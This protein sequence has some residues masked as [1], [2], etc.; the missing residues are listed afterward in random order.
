MSSPPRV[1]ALFVG[2]VGNFSYL[3]PR[4]EEVSSNFEVANK[5]TL[6]SI[7]TPSSRLVAPRRWPFPK[8]NICGRSK[9]YSFSRA[10]DPLNFPTT[11]TI[12][13]TV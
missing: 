13:A 3:S 2:I 1:L 6:P 12:H 10:V 11:K 4:E 9:F 8:K 7:H 5:G